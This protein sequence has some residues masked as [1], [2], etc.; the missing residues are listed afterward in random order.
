MYYIGLMSGTSMDAVDTALLDFENSSFQ[1][2]EYTQ[3]P[4]PEA[5]RAALRKITTR[6]SIGKITR[7][8]SMLGHLF[9]DSVLSMIAQTQIPPREIAAIGCHGQTVMHLPRDKYP[10]TL[11]IGDANIIAC[12]TGIRTVADFRR[13]D[14]AA[15][16]EG[17]PL[18][19]AFHANYF[20][21]EGI[22][23]V[24]LNIGGIANITILASDPDA[25]ITGF[26]TGPGNGLLDDWHQLHRG[27]G[28]DTEGNWAGSGKT[29]NELLKHLLNEPFF[30]AP[31]PKS[32]GRD[33]FNLDWLNGKL[34]SWCRRP[35]AEDVQATL[36]ALTAHSI[37]GAIRQ[38]AP[39]TDEIYICGGGVHN[40]LLIKGLKERLPGKKIESTETLGVH[41]DAV[42][43]VTFAWLAKRRV[44]KLSGNLPSVTGAE[45]AVILGAEFYP[46]NRGQA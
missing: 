9:A 38:H 43:A 24:I 13:M 19:P 23:R 14:M 33:F 1:V 37:A 39:H 35:A 25:A 29:N 2:I 22:N 18:A 27:T 32:T 30:T 8:D 16:G 3:Y 44:D 6:T 12:K 17:A 7:L 4:F 21:A 26:D 45:K 15:G 41:P 20:R 34:S 31:P 10:R 40:P 11:Q 5:L 42:E 28:M 46:A 36:L